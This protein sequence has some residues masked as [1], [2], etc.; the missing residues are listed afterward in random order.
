MVR[1]DYKA[2]CLKRIEITD[3][4]EIVESGHRPQ[5]GDVV[6]V[7]ITEK[8]GDYNELDL[9]GGELVEIEEGDIVLGTF[10]NRA[11]VKGYIGEVPDEVSE[12]DRIDFIGSGGVFG[13]CLSAAKNLGEPCEAEFLGYV[14]QDEK[15]LNMKDYGIERVE[16]IEGEPR[17]VGVVSTRMDAG[18]TTLAT[19][20]IENLSEE[21]EVGSLKLTGSAR[22]RDRVSMF[23]S[24]SEI[25]LD[26]VD[27]GLPS[28]VDDPE[29]VISSA[30]GLINHAW[31]EDLDFI[32][33]EFGAGLI[34]NYHVQEVLRDLDV[35]NSIFSICGVSLDVMGAY[36]LKKVLTDLDYELSFMSGPITDT[37]V[38]KDT[39]EDYVG[40]P[41]LNAFS[42]EEMTEAK[43]ILAQSFE[44]FT[45]PRPS[46]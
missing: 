1:H 30:K 5:V 37:T 4:S 45:A 17:L 20:I 25:S 26:F 46:F 33:I 3:S 34:S 6:A 9:P 29:I 43:E 28:T 11:G 39:V 21:Y 24:G 12:G 10:G 31:N 14:S 42:E 23:E 36:G 16:E 32:V 35:K 15:I 7:K 41:A 40:V 2:S 18:K 22:E 44:E 38:G 27:A 19:K 8:K 13:D